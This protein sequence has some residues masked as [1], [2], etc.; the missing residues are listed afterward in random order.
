MACIF[1]VFALPDCAGFLSRF[2]AGEGITQDFALEFRLMWTAEG[3]AG[4]EA[5]WVEGTR[6]PCRFGTIGNDGD[7]DGGD[8]GHFYFSLDCNYNPVAEGSTG[9]E[10]DAVGF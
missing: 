7:E 1:W 10:N 3:M 5:F 2:P 9:G 4:S 6:G 8:A